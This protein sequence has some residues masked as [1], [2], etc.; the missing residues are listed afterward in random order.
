L[1][2]LG[3]LGKMHGASARRGPK[4]KFRGGWGLQTESK[5]R[6]AGEEAR[7]GGVEQGGGENGEGAAKENKGGA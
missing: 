6:R 3:G 2:A 4:P 5:G 1:L 7:V